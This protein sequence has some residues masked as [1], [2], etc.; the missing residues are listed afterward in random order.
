ME[1]CLSEMG[2]IE[3]P[4]IHDWR[5]NEQHYGAL[6]GLS[7]TK[8]AEKYGRNKSLSG[9]EVTRFLLLLLI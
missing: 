5:L 9:A 3:I 8:T 6:E 1:I 2:P 4:T 7:K